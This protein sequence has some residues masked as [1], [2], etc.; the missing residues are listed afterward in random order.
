MPETATKFIRDSGDQSVFFFYLEIL[1]LL[2]ESLG[3]EYTVFIT[4]GE[5]TPG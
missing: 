3:S 5:P 2:M 4:N 1:F